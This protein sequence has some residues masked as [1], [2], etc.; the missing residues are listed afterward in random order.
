MVTMVFLMDTQLTTV[1]SIA[2]S[3]GALQFG[4]VLY[5]SKCHIT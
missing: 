4:I 3:V 5:H 1:K 2:V